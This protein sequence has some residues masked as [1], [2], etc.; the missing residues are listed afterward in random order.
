MASGKNQYWSQRLLNMFSGATGTIATPMFLAL[1]TVAPT[2]STA[3]TE[4]TAA[5][6]Y[7]SFS[8]TG[9]STN[10]PV[11][12][13][14]TT[15]LSSGTAFFNVTAATADWSSAAL[16]VAA[17]LKD[18]GTNGAGNLYY[19]GSLTESKIV[20]NGDTPSFAI[21]AVTIQEL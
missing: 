6:S 5:G 8:I 18:S 15:T 16:I 20:Y 12:S 13:G 1:Y 19:F 21:G 9:N 14:S 2:V 3:G 17:G 4:V 10:W 11:I 7:A